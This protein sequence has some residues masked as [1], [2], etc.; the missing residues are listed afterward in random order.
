MYNHFKQL[1]IVIVIG[2]VIMAIPSITILSDEQ[3]QESEQYIAFTPSLFNDHSVLIPIKFPLF[4]INSNSDQDMKLTIDRV[5]FSFNDFASLLN[6]ETSDRIE[7][8][9]DDY[10]TE[11]QKQKESLIQ[12]IDFEMDEEQEKEQIHQEI[13]EDVT[14]FLEEFLPE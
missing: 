4:K 3:Q 9:H 13:E 14:S 11:V 10:Y 5:T 7:N 12:A 2:S 1:F 8:Y 6:K